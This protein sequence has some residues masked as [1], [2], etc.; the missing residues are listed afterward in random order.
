V[1]AD[2]SDVTVPLLGTSFLEVTIQGAYARWGEQ[3]LVYTG[4]STVT[5]SYS[6]LK[7]V[8]LSGDFENVLSFGVDVNVPPASRS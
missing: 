4:P 6:A 3:E 5:P 1:R 8:K 7:Q 2:P